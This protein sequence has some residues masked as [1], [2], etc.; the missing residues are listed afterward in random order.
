MS[1]A[2]MYSLHF[3]TAASK[4]SREKFDVQ[5]S[6]GSPLTEMSAG[7]RLSVGHDDESGRPEAAHVPERVGTEKA[8][9]ADSLSADHALEQKCARSLLDPAVGADGR[10][11]IAHQPPV[12]GN[13]IGAPGQ[14]LER[15][16]IR[17]I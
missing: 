6:V 11:C 10:Q 2:R 17:G 5:A 9:A 4:P 1:P 8:V 13:Q 15:L 16:V 12:D 14:P 3:S 7:S